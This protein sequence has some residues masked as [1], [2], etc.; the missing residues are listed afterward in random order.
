MARFP[1]TVFVISI[2]QEAERMANQQ[3]QQQ[4]QQPQSQQQQ[5]QQLPPHSSAPSQSYGGASGPQAMH[6]AT[7]PHPQVSSHSPME[8]DTLKVPVDRSGMAGRITPEHLRSRS[9]QAAPAPSS[10]GVNTGG[11]EIGGNSLRHL[12]DYHRLSSHHHHHQKTQSF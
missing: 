2:L 10:G 5:Q 9:P 6:Q 1:T 4:Q 3:Q 7:H 12:P 8:V 11:G